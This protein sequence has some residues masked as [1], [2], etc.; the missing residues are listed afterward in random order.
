MYIDQNMVWGYSSNLCQVILAVYRF[1]LT[2]SEGLTLLGSI[3]LMCVLNASVLYNQPKMHAPGEARTH[4][5][6]MASQVL[7]ISTAR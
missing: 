2:K 4:N 3:P 6:R 5:L 7:L 1:Q